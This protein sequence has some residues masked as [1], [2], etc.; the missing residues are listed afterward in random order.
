M[1]DK[2]AS[3]SYFGLW[4]FIKGCLYEIKAGIVFKSS[5]F[6]SH[7]YSGVVDI[8]PALENLPVYWENQIHK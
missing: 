4:E 6:T 8:L 3:S 7:H 5:T 1:N 2:F